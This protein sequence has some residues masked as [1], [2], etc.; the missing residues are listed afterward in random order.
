MPPTGPTAPVY[1]RGSVL[2]AD[3]VAAPK[4]IV[5]GES[6]TY[7]ITVYNGADYDVRDVILTDTLPM[8]FTFEEMI[9]SKPSGLGS[10]V[11]ETTL[12]W[13]I[14]GTI[15]KNGGEFV[16]V[17]KAQTATE[18]EGMFSATYYNQLNARAVNIDTQETVIVPS[19]GPI[20]P[21]DV[22]GLS[23]VRADK[24]VT[25]KQIEAGESVTYTIILDN[26]ATMQRTLRIT[27]TLPVSFTLDQP[28]SPTTVVLPLHSLNGHQQVV[29][30]GVK[31]GPQSQ[32][33]LTFRVKTDSDIEIGRYENSL[34]VGVGPFVQPKQPGLAP[35][36][37][38][39]TV[40]KIYLPLVIRKF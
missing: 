18:D 32:R 25:P 13:E 29:W 23:P 17:F 39:E 9:S 40:R 15:E 26:N 5:A 28:I 38:I 11:G 22:V 1:V 4:K 2:Q 33:R 35:V 6:V 7:T 21:V 3:K 20:A 19:T 8:G 31:V 24:D 16:I 34:Q 30:D 12:V 36:Q 27:D 37:I 10:P 14:P